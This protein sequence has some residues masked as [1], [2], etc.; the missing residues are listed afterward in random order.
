MRT[1]HNIAVAAAVS[2]IAVL[3][4]TA[5]IKQVRPTDN[6][7]LFGFGERHLKPDFIVVAG[8][9]NIGGHVAVCGLVFFT[10][11]GSQAVSYEPFITQK[12]KFS[13]G[14]TRLRVQT[15]AFRR[16]KTEELALAGTAGCSVTSVPW[17][18][19][20]QTLPLE[21]NSGD[22]SIKLSGGSSAEKTL[23]PLH[24]D[25]IDVAGDTKFERLTPD[26]SS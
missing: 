23:H 11:I 17:Q 1:I 25:E 13:I 4:A 16:Y 19:A 6:Y 20:Y 3:P 18:P 22:V 10:P 26:H 15:G 2:L 24:A 21:M 8:V 7:S 9:E 14:G 12:L 5:G